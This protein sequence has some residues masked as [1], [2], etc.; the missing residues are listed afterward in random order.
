MKLTTLQAGQ[1]AVAP[2]FLTEDDSSIVQLDLRPFG[3]N[4]VRSSGLLN[5]P[6]QPMDIR[7]RAEIG[8]EMIRD[9][10]RQ[11]EEAFHFE[12]LKL[13][14][15]RGLTPMT[16]QQVRAIR[17][18]VERLLSPILGRQHSELLG[19][20]IDRVFG[21]AVR[22]GKIPPAPAILQGRRI[23]VEYQSPI[24][25]A[26]REAESEA[27]IDILSLVAQMGQVDQDVMDLVD[28]EEL[29]RFVANQKGVPP[30]LLRSRAAVSRIRAAQRVVAGEEQQK[31]DQMRSVEMLGKLAPML[32]GA[33]A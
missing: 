29:V 9:T 15:N 12:L 19:P 24:T 3:R 11:V 26:Q 22:R 6:I 21:I 32:K 25:R 10:R 17:S 20:L 14:Q 1:M 18:A 5:P 33:A 2:P 30:K 8:V 13:I 31:E 4:I 16:A 27:A 23:E 28:M 7:S